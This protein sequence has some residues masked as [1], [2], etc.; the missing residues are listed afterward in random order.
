MRDGDDDEDPLECYEY[1]PDHE[2]SPFDVERELRASEF[3]AK[4]YEPKSVEEFTGKDY[5]LI[6]CIY[7]LITIYLAIVAT[8]GKSLLPSMGNPPITELLSLSSTMLRPDAPVKGLS[9]GNPWNVFQKL[10]WN[11]VVT[12]CK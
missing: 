3:P 12:D 11:D 7:F 9:A 5:T 4:G 2:L 10:F 6:F 1:T 8:L